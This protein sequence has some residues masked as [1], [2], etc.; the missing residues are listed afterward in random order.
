MAIT[1]AC[2]DRFRSNLAQS[3]TMW[4]PIHSFKAKGSKVKVT[5]YVRDNADWLRNLCAFVAYLTVRRGVAPRDL[6]L[7]LPGGTS[8][9]AI[10]SNK[11]NPE[12]ADNMPNRLARNRGGLRVAMPSQLHAFYTVR[13]KTAL[14]YFCNN[15]AKPPYIKIDFAQIWH[16]GS[17]LVPENPAIVEIHLPWNPRWRTAPKFSIFKWL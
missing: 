15:L 9:N 8:Q 10:F 13:Q 7:W 16:V 6:H 2:I 1:R 14:C 4:Q 5:A 12:N 17:V 3:F 11:K